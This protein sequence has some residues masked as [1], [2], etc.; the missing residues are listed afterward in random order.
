MTSCNKLW[1]GPPLSKNQA[2][3]FSEAR[4]YGTRYI[5]PRLQFLHCVTIIAAVNEWPL[6]TIVAGWSMQRRQ[7]SARCDE[8]I[9]PAKLRATPRPRRADVL[10]SMAHMKEA[11]RP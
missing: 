2:P 5:R 8:D 3:D 7:A 6:Q 4:P 1:N 9:A 11:R 10:S